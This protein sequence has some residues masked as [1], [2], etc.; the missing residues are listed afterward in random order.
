MC[1]S[2]SGPIFD[3]VP[4]LNRTAFRRLELQCLSLPVKHHLNCPKRLCLLNIIFQNV[5]T[6][7]EMNPVKYTAE[8]RS[9]HLSASTHDWL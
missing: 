3:V 4:L 5:I 1:N 6:I 7:M 9:V 2:V 8:A